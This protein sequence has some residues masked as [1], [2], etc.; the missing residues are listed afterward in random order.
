MHKYTQQ[1]TKEPV[2]GEDAKLMHEAAEVENRLVEEQAPTEQII[3]QLRTERAQESTLTE[4]QARGERIAEL[5]RRLKASREARDDAS[6]GA[7]S[8]EQAMARIR[9]K[10]QEEGRGQD[11]DGHA[12]GGFYGETHKV[13]DE[14]K[15][16]Q[17]VAAKETRKKSDPAKDDDGLAK[18]RE[19]ERLEKES[20]R[21]DVDPPTPG[22]D[23]GPR[24]S[25]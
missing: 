8:V 17:E 10:R 1:T 13:L 21:R 19:A 14:L 24:Y 6:P 4:E 16:R 3:D 20:R 18:M 22:H 5:S 15:A 7:E 12:T 11:K 23:R 25:R 2:S 9:A